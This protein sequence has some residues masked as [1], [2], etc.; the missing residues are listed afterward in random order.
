MTTLKDRK[1][2][3]ERENKDKRNR[4][5]DNRDTDN[6]NNGDVSMHRLSDKRKSAQKVD[7]FGGNSN[8]VSHDDKDA[9]K[10]E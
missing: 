8:F 9:L 7:N 5:Q 3:A 6:E 1:K 10:S 4:Y 2:R